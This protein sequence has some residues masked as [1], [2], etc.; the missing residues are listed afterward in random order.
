MSLNSLTKLLVI[1]LL[2]LLFTAVS[3]NKPTEPPIEDITPGRRDYVWTIDTISTDPFI[4]IRRFWGST[5]NDIWAVGSGN[6]FH[7]NGKKWMEIEGAEAIYPQTIFGFAQNNVWAAGYNKIWHFD[8]TS[9]SLSSEK[10]ISGF[11]TIFFDNIWG[12]SP[13]NIYAIGYAQGSDTSS[14]GVILRYDGREWNFLN[15]PKININFTDIRKVNS[16][17]II[18]G[19][20]FENLIFIEKLYQFTGINLHELYS[21][22]D[23]PKLTYLNNKL[24]IKIGKEIF[25]Y[26]EGTLELVHNFAGTEYWDGFWGRTEKDFFCVTGSG[27]GHYNGSDLATI[28]KFDINKLSPF[29]EL[30]FD[31]EVFFLGRDDQANISI[32]I[33]GR[34]ND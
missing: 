7:F 17:L 30:L 31:K 34:L 15:I 24:F 27:L 3:C 20:K 11:G 18:C 2:P 29:S 25:K 9:W 4:Y 32:V 22:S 19:L 10:Y 21:G 26:K 13:N 6:L 14:M 1:I 16:D 8:G 33:K 28:Y 23:Y 5:P 12:D